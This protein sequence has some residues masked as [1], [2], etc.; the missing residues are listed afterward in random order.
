M[1]KQESR[2]L[3]RVVAALLV[4]VGLSLLFAA[5]TVVFSHQVV[6]Y[7]LSRPSGTDPLDQ[8]RRA[9]T[10]TIWVRAVLVI[11]AAAL[12]VWLVR[13][14]RHGSRRAYVRIRTLSVIGLIAVAYLLISGQYPSWLRVV[15]AAQVASLLALVVAVT[16]PSV[17]AQ[18]P[19]QP[20][21]QRGDR[22][23]ALALV[24]LTPL[25][26]EVTL[27][28]TPITK[29]WLVLLWLPIYGAGVLLIR[30]LARRHRAGWPGVLLLGVAY[31]IVEEGIALQALSSP[32]LYH[33][34]DWAPR[35][36]GVNSAYTE[37]MLSYHA[38]FSVAIPILLTELIFPAS[39]ARPY[40]GRGGLT[41]TA[42]IALLGVVLLRLAV[43]PNE[44]PGYTMPTPV[45]AGCV[46]AVLLLGVLALVVLP[47]RGQRQQ[48]PGTP[49]KP[50]TSCV[51]GALATFAFLA[52]LFPFAGAKHPAFTHGN[53]VV[54]PM[55]GAAVLAAVIG[56]LIHRWSVM[57]DWS[58][59]RMLALAS[60]ALIAHT[61][62]GAIAIP[63]RILDLAGLIIL[64]VI[65]I[66]GLVLLARLVR[67]RTHNQ[68]V[69]PG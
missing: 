55:V 17:R 63:D 44:D 67:K 59:R 47:R 24:L 29:V 16:R 51:G 6:A 52:L 34:G 11:G 32:T 36:F 42:I 41:A 13:R 23:A 64:G 22:R 43:P 60:G 10:V 14:L 7:Q 69:L 18:F 30:E 35:L 26:A 5:L 4:S 27:G 12:Y 53:W 31:G 50:W 9:L 57:N 28:S 3:D 68:H 25:V 21:P 56:W 20:R 66:G 45:L 33:A 49:P 2:P 46:V 48:R 65:M 19:K 8:A 38:I 39:R 61:A 37:V 15:Q 40:L 58:D 62:F 54:V 1:T